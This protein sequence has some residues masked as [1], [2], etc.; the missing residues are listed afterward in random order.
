MRELYSEIILDLNKNPL[1][2]KEIE[3]NRSSEGNNPLCG[4]RVKVFVDEQD[5]TI[6]EVSFIGE[7]CA[8]SIASASVMTKLVKGLNIEE[9]CK[10][11]EN[12]LKMI[13]N[14]DYDKDLMKRVEFLK[15]VG[16]HPSRIKC[17]TL[18]WH[19]LKDAIEC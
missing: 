15:E 19:A 14:E 9:A 4:D 10:T 16:K 6:E 8:I 13:K 5:R 11:I 7:G 3:H 17:A 1:N 12:F 2:K 18:C